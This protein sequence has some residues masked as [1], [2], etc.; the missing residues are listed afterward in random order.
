MNHQQQQPPPPRTPSPLS[1]PFYQT[2]DYETVPQYGKI[3]DP[4]FRKDQLVRPASVAK[5]SS[6]Y[7]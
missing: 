5:A 7:F 3:Y 2:A 6:P 4:Y 1:K